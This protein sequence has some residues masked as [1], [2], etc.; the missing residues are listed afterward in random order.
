MYLI[1][2]GAFTSA[3][4]VIYIHILK[5]YCR[6]LINSKYT[7]FSRIFSTSGKLFIDLKSTAQFEFGSFE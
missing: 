4:K 3:I 2:Q 7:T 6:L 5:C 1:F